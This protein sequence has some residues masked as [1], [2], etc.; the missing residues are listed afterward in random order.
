MNGA[1]ARC[2][3]CGVVDASP[4]FGRYQA[5][6]YFSQHREAHAGSRDYEGLGLEDLEGPASSSGQQHLS[7]LG[8]YVVIPPN[9]ARR[10]R[11]QKIANK[12]LEDLAKLKEQYKPGLINLTPQKLGGR[13]SEAE[14]RQKQQLEHIQ[15]KYQQKANKLEEKQRQQEW[16]RQQ[17][18]DE[19]HHLKTTEFLKRLDI[20]PC[21]RTPCQTDHHNLKST[22]WTRSQ[23]Y[24]QIQRQEENRKLQE[25][26]EEQRRKAELLELKQRQEERIRMK[27][28]Q[29]EQRRVNN[30][31]LDRLQNSCQPGG[32]YQS[33]RRGNMDFSADSWEP[34]YFQ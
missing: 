17:M 25:M 14:V 5:G 30:E 22:A 34:E 20:S 6:D 2:G 28:H 19:D 12:E 27:A 3:R 15:S 21:R 32:M 1:G 24:K 29:N 31:F 23:S 18:L 13:I 10:N 16:Q 4:F 8:A 11:L 33:G 26:K 9:P 7:S